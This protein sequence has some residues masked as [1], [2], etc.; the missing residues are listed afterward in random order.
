MAKLSP[1]RIQEFA[2][3]FQVEPGRRVR[4]PRDFDTDGQR[5]QSNAEAK[6]ILATASS[7]SLSTRP[8]SPRRTRTAW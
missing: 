4:L 1:K 5:S 6:A 2:R 7:C 8:V 3:R